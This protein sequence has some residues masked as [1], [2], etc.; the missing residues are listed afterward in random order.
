MVFH[1][2]AIRPSS[3]DYRSA[4]VTVRVLDTSEYVN[5]KA[6]LRALRCAL[7]ALVLYAF[8]TRGEE[9]ACGTCTYVV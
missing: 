5:V 9:C 7:Q 4:Q 8:F 2:L 6:L 1:E 3:T